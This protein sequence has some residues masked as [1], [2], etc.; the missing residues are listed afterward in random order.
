[1]ICNISLLFFTLVVFF[2]SNMSAHQ[3]IQDDQDLTKKIVD[4]DI[5][6]KTSQILYCKKAVVRL[7]EKLEPV[8]YAKKKEKYI[9]KKIINEQEYLKKLLLRYEE[10][11]NEVKK[12][13]IDKSIFSAGNVILG[14]I[15]WADN[16]QIGYTLF[17]ISGALCFI[18]ALNEYY[19]LKRIP[20]AEQLK[21]EVLMKMLDEKLNSTYIK[22]LK[23]RAN[24]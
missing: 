20:K 22:L 21:K 6:K 8:K 12:R 7:I 4:E 3:N 13:I 11:R 16:N 17:G 9:Q 2:S 10:K 24:R 1:M 15:L 23:L 19:Y 14:L 18:N 5:L